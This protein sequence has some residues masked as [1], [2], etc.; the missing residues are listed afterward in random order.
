MGQFNYDYLK[1]KEIHT[2]GEE[3]IRLKAIFHVG[4]FNSIETHDKAL[5][6]VITLCPVVVITQNNYSVLCKHR[7]YINEERT[8]SVLAETANSKFICV[9]SS[10]VNYE[11]LLDHILHNALYDQDAVYLNIIV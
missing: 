1:V 10:S 2:E 7:R 8:P 9:N 3:A 4:L 11:D 5:M 6:E